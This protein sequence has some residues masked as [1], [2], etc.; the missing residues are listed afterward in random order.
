MKTHVIMLGMVVALAVPMAARAQ[1]AGTVTASAT[2]GD[3]L[4]VV[5]EVP[6]DF[7]TVAPNDNISVGAADAGAGYVEFEYNRGYEVTIT[8]LPTDLT[9]S[10]GTDV[11]T[12]TSWE[13]GLSDGVGN[14]ITNVGTCD[15]ATPLVQNNS[16]AAYGT[17]VVYLGGAFSVPVTALAG[18]YSADVVFQISAF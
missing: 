10:N 18:T 17:Q 7:G 15:A 6:L 1:A 12:M 4:Q 13:C 2:V 14:P 9:H 3:V 11:I 5:D 16:V 8:A